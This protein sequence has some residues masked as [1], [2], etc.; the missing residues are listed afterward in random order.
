VQRAAWGEAALLPQTQDRV[1]SSEFLLKQDFL[2]I[3]LGVQRPTVTLVMETLQDAG[4]MATTYG[5]IRVLKRRRLERASCE[6]YEVIR[7]HFQ[8]LGL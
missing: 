4:L 8:R 1:G 2:A 5:R 6:C 7:A 3:M